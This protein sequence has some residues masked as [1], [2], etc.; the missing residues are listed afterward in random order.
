MRSRKMPFLSPLNLSSVNAY[1]ITND[2]G[3]SDFTGVFLVPKRPQV[4]LRT[5][6]QPYDIVRRAHHLA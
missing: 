1:S 3:R 6:K 5:L 4:K 2:L